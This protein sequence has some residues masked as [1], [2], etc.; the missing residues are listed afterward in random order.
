MKLRWAWTLAAALGL[1]TLEPRAE[2]LVLRPVADTSLF[3]FNPDNNLGATDNLPVGTINKGRRCRLLMRFD[4]T[5]ALPPGAVVTQATLTL[6]V[7]SSGGVD[8]TF[9]LRHV[10]QAWSEGAKSGN[11]GAAAG[12]GESTWNARLFPAVLWGEP[13]GA[14]GTDF[15]PDV[16]AALPLGAPGQYSFPSTPAM[17]ADVQ[18]WVT[19]PGANYGWVLMTDAEATPAT[20]KRVAAREDATHAPTLTLEYTPR[21]APRID[22]I[23]RAGEGVEIHFF[24]PAGKLYGLEYNP[25]LLG[26]GWSNLTLVAAKFFATNMVVVEPPPLAPR[27]FYRVADLGDI[28]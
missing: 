24:V 8:S 26:T 17:V 5:G 9:Q 14:L 13:G 2:T 27:R 19:N 22:G 3:E 28:D 21:T 11:T 6:T 1:P 15:L 10:L 18:S 23:V 12:A 20:A 25:D 4:L 16:R 7:L